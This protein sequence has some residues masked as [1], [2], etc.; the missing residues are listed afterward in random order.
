MRTLVRSFD[1]FLRR[2]LGIVALSSDPEC[3]LRVRITRSAHTVSLPGGHVSAGAQV[4]E[5]HLWNERVPPM[6]PEGPDLA[7]ARQTQR[8]FLGSLREAA[9]QLRENP[10][11]AGVQAVAGTTVLIFGADGVARTKLVQSLGFSVFPVHSS[12]GRFGELWEN[13]YTRAL[14]WAYNPSSVRDLR[15]TD[16]HRDEFWIARDAFLDRFGR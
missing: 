13:S 10:G 11:M 12:L 15:I 2:C 7:W 3:L 5:L 16:M 4:L 8:L 14:M 6:P 9:R 1:A